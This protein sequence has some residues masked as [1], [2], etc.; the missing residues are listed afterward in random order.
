MS[1]SFE[2]SAFGYCRTCHTI[3]TIGEG[4]ARKF[5]MEL[6]A[7][8]DEHK[9]LDFETPLSQANPHFSTD[10]L[11]GELRGQMFGILEC[12]NDKGEQVILKAFSCQHDGEWDIPGWAPPLV[13]SEAYLKRVREGAIEIKEMS[14]FMEQ[15]TKGGK[16]WQTLKAERKSYSQQLM[17]ELHDMYRLHNFKGEE[18]T[19][20]EAFCEDKGIPTGTGDC[21]APKLLNWAAQLGLKP[22]GLAEF[23]WGRENSSGTK[24]HKEFYQACDIRCQPILGFLLCGADHE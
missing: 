7:Q 11:W 2:I 12:L 17:I 19:L 14:T 15:F 4:N 13:D 5:C 9:R 21:C 24:H 23:F 20:R 22:L 3:H 1:N 18:A 10:C 16:E 8:L 6:I